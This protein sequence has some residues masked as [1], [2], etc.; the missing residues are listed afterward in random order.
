MKLGNDLRL[1]VGKRASWN[2]SY[3]EQGVHN[4]NTQFIKTVYFESI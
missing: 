3:S 4:I 2:K 1:R